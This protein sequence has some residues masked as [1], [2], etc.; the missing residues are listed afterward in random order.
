MGARGPKATPAPILKMRGT[1]RRD[2]HSDDVQI[3]L[4]TP[5]CPTDLLSSES[6]G[7]WN[8]VVPML[9]IMGV[10]AK[11]DGNA[12]ARYCE[13]WVRWWKAAH[14]IRENGDTYCVYEVGPDGKERVRRLYDRPEVA[15]VKALAVELRAIEGSF[16]MSPSAR[17]QIRLP[18]KT[19]R[20][21]PEQKRKERFFNA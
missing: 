16:G 13:L 19:E 18:E 21:S 12:L 14:H 6:Q 1:F 9:E 11:I 7:V 17:S 3:E 5:D 8:Q 20:T 10:L 4:G 2:R 15:T